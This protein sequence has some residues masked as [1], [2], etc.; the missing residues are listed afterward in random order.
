MKSGSIFFFFWQIYKNGKWKQQTAVHAETRWRVRLVT[1]ASSI[2]CI[3]KRVFF[4]LTWIW[5][6]DSP[7]FLS[8]DYQNSTIEE[9][10]DFHI[11]EQGPYFTVYQSSQLDLN[12]IRKRPAEDWRFY[13]PVSGHW[14]AEQEVRGCYRL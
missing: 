13:R 5:I 4:C 14:V 1:I 9:Y 10:I 7:D 8:L 2:F 3:I 12:S 6:I 11:L